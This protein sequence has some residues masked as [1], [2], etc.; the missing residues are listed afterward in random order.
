MHKIK[1]T[2]R[3]I[4][5]WGGS[6][7]VLLPVFAQDSNIRLPIEEIEQRMMYQPFEIFRFRDARF[8]GDIT[9]RGI[10]RWPDGTV[11]QVKWKRSAPG[12]WAVNN[13][14]RYEIAAYELQKLFLDPQEYVVPPTCGN[15]LPLAQYREIEPDVK[16]TFKN[17]DSV[18]FVLQYWLEEVTQGKIYDKKRF[19]SDSTY[20]R[21]LGNMNILSYL[22]K[23]ND[24]NVGNFLI[25]T[26]PANPRVFAVD[27][28]LAFG[29]LE[30]NRG[31][32]W[33]RIRV[34]RLPLKTVDRLRTVAEEDLTQTLGVVAQFEIKEGRLM[35][36]QPT[37][38]LNPNKG[39]R[40]SKRFIQFGLTRSEIRGVSDRMRK[41]LKRVDSGKIK[42]F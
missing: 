24:S 3:A 36:A 37:E 9:K 21:H 1:N 39:V 18:F 27:N 28:G 17:T 35:P 23:H 33:R 38:N 29:N 16:P 26:D 32:E 10:L 7:A 20:A 40:V 11:M 31:V 22:I 25:S 41:L 19:K 34:K 2:L 15:S 14:P 8:E 12:G 13:Q 5:F 4:L 42:T 30:S 6:L